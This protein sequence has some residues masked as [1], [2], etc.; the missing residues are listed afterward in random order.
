MTRNLASALAVAIGIAAAAAAATIASGTAHAE[1]ITV[2]STPFASSRSR[3][4]VRAELLGQPALA[5]SAAS[6]WSMQ[7]NQLPVVKSSYT[8]DQVKAEYKSSRDDVSAL[9]AEDS[10]S[11]YFLKRSI[12][13]DA[14]SMG[15]PAR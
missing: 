15:G 7:S 9:N 10:G 6:E 14:T 1:D 11:S 3:A 8:S 12:R 4:D 2:D 13:P 5:R